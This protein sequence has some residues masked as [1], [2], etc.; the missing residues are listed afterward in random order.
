MGIS[1]HRV[2]TGPLTSLG[3]VL[4]LAACSIGLLIAADNAVA[5]ELDSLFYR[6]DQTALCINFML[7]IAVVKSPEIEQ[8]LDDHSL[9]VQ[10]L[11]ALEVRRSHRFKNDVVI[12][13]A[14]IRELRYSKFNDEY[15]L[16][17]KGKEVSVSNSYYT[18][19]DR[20]RR[21][22]TVPVIDLYLLEP[23][24]SYTVVL[25]IRVRAGPSAHRAQSPGKS[26]AGIGVE[27]ATSQ[28]YPDLGIID[29][30]KKRRDFAHIEYES[31]KFAAGALP[32]PMFSGP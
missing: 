24:E 5:Y 19:L 2:P 7:P 31:G 17:E 32:R 29:L 9:T 22:A 18:S 10:C 26:L 13:S 15:V 6:V 11:V 16:T 30:F 20:L 21:F 8:A 1:Q 28:A 27:Q 3:A 14:V 4:S 23:D 25:D 12:K